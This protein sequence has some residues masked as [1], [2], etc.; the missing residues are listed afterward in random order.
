MIR[1]YDMQNGVSV[2]HKIISYDN[3]GSMSE[4]DTYDSSNNLLDSV[5]VTNNNDSRLASATDSQYG[6]GVN[7]YDHLGQRMM[8]VQGSLSTIYLYDIFGNLIMEADT[9]INP[10]QTYIYLGNHRLAL[11]AGNFS[12]SW[13]GITNGLGPS[14]KSNWAII[15]SIP[16]LIF[17]AIKYRKK[18][19]VIALVILAGG[20]IIL[21]VAK[22]AKT[23]TYGE[24]IYYYHNDHLGTPQKMTDANRVV[25][26]DA[27]YEPFGKIDSKPVETVVNDMRFPGQYEDEGTGMYY[28]W[29]RYYMPDVGRYNRVDPYGFEIS[30]KYFALEHPYIYVSSNPLI[31]LDEN[32]LSKSD[33]QRMYE[34][35]EKIDGWLAKH[36]DN[37]LKHYCSGLWLACDANCS[38]II[39]ECSENGMALCDQCKKDCKES[40]GNC[41]KRKGFQIP[42][43]IQKMC[44]SNC[45]NLCKG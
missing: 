40:Y 15:I 25:A 6:T 8:R 42:P 33:C 24:A 22:E 20:A 43:I 26:W 9:N 44:T 17:L 11:I 13:C 28:N 36:L 31:Y 10:I 14:V 12:G 32:G 38:E 19:H 3:V 37:L 39:S 23:Y 35:A 16:V 5:T 4:L 7:Y 30:I 2:D 21:L 29:N 45:R 1:Y 18:R 34:N 27:I 41:L